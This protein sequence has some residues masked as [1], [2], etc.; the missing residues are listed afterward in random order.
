MEYLWDLLLPTPPMNVSLLMADRCSRADVEM[1]AGFFHHK[2]LIQVMSKRPINH[3][4]I[5]SVCM[6]NDL[7]SCN[8]PTAATANNMLC[9]NRNSLCSTYTGLANGSIA[10]YTTSQEYCIVSDSPLPVVR[11]CVDMSWSGE[12]PT[13]MEGKGL[14]WTKHLWL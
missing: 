6:Q 3:R 12:I 5:F 4:S 11:T 7:L 9:C 13:I 1:I 14:S 2:G 10:T 8:N